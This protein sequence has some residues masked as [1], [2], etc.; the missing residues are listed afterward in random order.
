M[1]KTRVIIKW[2][3]G[4]VA[5]TALILGS[6]SAPAEAARDT[7]WGP[8]STKSSSG[9]APLRDTGWGPV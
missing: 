9:T 3:A 1:N 4:T 2:F 7:G 5:A 6:V 8:V